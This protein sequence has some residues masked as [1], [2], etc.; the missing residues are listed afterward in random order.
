MPLKA[1]CRGARPA[2]PRDCLTDSR[3]GTRERHSGPPVGSGPG[4]DRIAELS[5]K[6]NYEVRPARTN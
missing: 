4:P 3:I 2:R 6:T 1:P 5:K